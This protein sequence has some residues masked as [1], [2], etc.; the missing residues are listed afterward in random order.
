MQI[1]ILLM[2]FEILRLF[3]FTGLAENHDLLQPYQNVE[4]NHSRLLLA[5]KPGAEEALIFP[6]LV[7]LTPSD[8]DII[9]NTNG[10]RLLRLTNTVLNL[11]PGPLEVRAVSS[12]KTGS[13]EVYQHIYYEDMETTYERLAGEFIFHPGHDHWHIEDFVHYELWGLTTWGEMSEKVANND[14][15]SYCLRDNASVPVDQPATNRHYLYCENKVQGISVDWVD[16]AAIT[17][18]DSPLRSMN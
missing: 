10:D 1:S 17:T 4:S 18:K 16:I 11:G 9:N 2:I 12:E 6:D 13:S 3:S 7:T 8:L 14:K 5:V 15:V